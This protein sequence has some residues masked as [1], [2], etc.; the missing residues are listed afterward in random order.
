[1]KSLWNVAVTGLVLVGGLWGASEALAA[2]AEP[3][4]VAPKTPAA[5]TAVVEDP[6]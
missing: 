4:A 5:A 6:Q 1:M 3:N 2:R